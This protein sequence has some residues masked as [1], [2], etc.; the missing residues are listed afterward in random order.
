M[1]FEVVFMNA[2]FD[3]A[4]AEFGHVDMRQVEI[5]QVNLRQSAHDLGV[6]G[7]HTLAWSCC[8]Q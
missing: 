8:V 1:S 2:S 6:P 7:R 3:A 5:V 4:S